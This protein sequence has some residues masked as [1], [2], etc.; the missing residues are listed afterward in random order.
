MTEV[1][2][3][4]PVDA[5]LECLRE[6]SAK[7]LSRISSSPQSSGELV[8]IAL[9]DRQ[10][11]TGLLRETLRVDDGLLVDATTCGEGVQIEAGDESKL[12]ELNEAVEAT[13]ERY[14]KV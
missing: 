2:S 9:D 5:V 12:N 7:H 4:V 14:N 13:L 11:F 3:R 6:L 10:R 8:A 1:A